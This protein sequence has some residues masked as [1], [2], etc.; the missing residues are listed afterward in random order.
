MN[1]S[2][3]ASTT[4]V[5][6]RLADGLNEQLTRARCCDALEPCSRCRTTA[7]EARRLRHQARVARLAKLA[8]QNSAF[9]HIMTV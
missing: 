7:E 6:A 5:A 2:R 4:A 9:R 3:T 8:A 1:T